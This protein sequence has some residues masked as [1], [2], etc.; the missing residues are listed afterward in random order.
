MLLE[1]ICGAICGAMLLAAIVSF[2]YVSAESGVL[3]IIAAILTLIVPRAYS[4]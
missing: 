3:W 4:R 2:A 1:K